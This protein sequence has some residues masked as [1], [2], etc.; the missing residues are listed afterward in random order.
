MSANFEYYKVFYYVAKYRS[1]TQA[2]GILMSSQPSISRT[3]KILEDELGCTLFTRT[4]KRRCTDSGRPAAL[5]P[6]QP[7]LRRDLRR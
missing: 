5:Y 2:A 6:Y 3:M 1:F 4:Q 7:C